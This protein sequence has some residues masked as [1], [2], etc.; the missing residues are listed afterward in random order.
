VRGSFLFSNV[1][2]N[3]SNAAVTGVLLIDAAYGQNDNRFRARKMHR[4]IIEKS[5][6]EFLNMLERE[7]A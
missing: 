4:E 7:E 3:F 5:Q 2:Y 1:E 6:P